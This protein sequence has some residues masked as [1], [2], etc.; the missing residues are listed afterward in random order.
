MGLCQHVFLIGQFLAVF[1]RATMNQ[2]QLIIAKMIGTKAYLS[3]APVVPL[4][5][6]V[7]DP[8]PIALVK[9]VNMS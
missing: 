4:M 6:P 3:S 8:D 2:N 5:P 7:A 9:T 1:Y